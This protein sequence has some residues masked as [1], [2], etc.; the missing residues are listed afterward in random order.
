MRLAGVTLAWNPA[1]KTTSEKPQVANPLRAVFAQI[2]SN[3]SGNI[4]TAE[5]TWA[6][7]KVG[8][9]AAAI[10]AQ[11]EAFCACSKD[12]SE[13]EGG[14][15]N[16]S[17][18]EWE[19][20][21]L[22][23]TRCAIEARLN[24]AGVIEGFE[25]VADY[26]PVYKRLM[27]HFDMDGSGKLTVAE[28]KRV[29]EALRMGSAKARPPRR[30]AARFGVIPPVESAGVRVHGPIRRRRRW[31]HL[32]RRVPWLALDGHARRAAQGDDRRR[33]HARGDYDQGD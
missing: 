5:V 14:A 15:D 25:A 4:S 11:L 31:L 28:L 19:K 16:V 24:D 21:L 26:A 2:D 3:G 27:Q 32:T 29:L 1:N 7:Q 13:L 23:E 18:A 33:G 6:L 17:L 22:P 9:S 10:S 12:L 20:G 30:P 8:L